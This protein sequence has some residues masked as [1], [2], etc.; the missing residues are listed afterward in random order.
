MEL[1]YVGPRRKAGSAIPLPE[2]WPAAD[3][4][5]PDA[6]RA[7]AKVR[8]GRYR[9]QSPPAPVHEAPKGND[10]PGSDPAPAQEVSGDG[11]RDTTV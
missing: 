8:S 1:R 3:H 6:A 4:V 7:E 5:E 11:N 9:Y 10:K 2:G